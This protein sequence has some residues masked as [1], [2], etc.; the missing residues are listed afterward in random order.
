MRPSQMPF[1]DYL[2]NNLPRV[3]LPEGVDPVDHY[4]DNNMAVIGTAE[5]AIAMI[6]RIRAKQ[7]PFGC[8]LLQG[9]NWAD[10]DAT[11]RSYELYARHVMPHHGEANRVRFWSYDVVTSRQQEFV[12]RRNLASQQMF[13]KHAAEEESTGDRGT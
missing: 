4:I 9:V 8:V 13:G 10:W 5:D 7:G 3:F 1:I 12:D 11:Q 6:D 2:N